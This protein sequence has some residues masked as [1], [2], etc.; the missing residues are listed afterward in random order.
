M[1]PKP[2]ISF[3]RQRV[4]FCEGDYGLNINPAAL[5]GLGRFG[6]ELK[7]RVKKGEEDLL[8]T[9]SVIRRSKFPLGNV[10]IRQV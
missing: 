3:G 10:E 9:V 7:K 4:G 8:H 1:L 6:R 5:M 2:A